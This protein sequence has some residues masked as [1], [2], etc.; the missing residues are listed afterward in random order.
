MMDLSLPVEE[1]ASSEHAVTIEAKNFYAF[2][3]FEATSSF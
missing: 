3:N 2:K 1:V